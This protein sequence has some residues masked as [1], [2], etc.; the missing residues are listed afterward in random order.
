MNKTKYIWLSAI[1]A[2]VK[3]SCFFG[4]FTLINTLFKQVPAGWSLAIMLFVLVSVT[5]IFYHENNRAKRRFIESDPSENPPSPKSVLRSADL[6]IDTAVC[7]LLSLCSAFAVGYSDIQA[8]FFAKTSIP[9][10]LQALLIGM[11]IGVVCFFVNWFTVYDVRKKWKRD[12]KLSSKNEILK[13]AAYLCF[14]TVL[15][16]IGFYIAMAYAVGLYTY[17]FLIKNYFW[18]ILTILAIIIAASFFLIFFRRLSKRKKFISKLKKASV[19]FGYTL[20]PIKRPYLSLFRKTEGESFTITAHGKSYS[21]KLISGKRKTSPMIFSDQGFLLFQH[22]FRLGKHE[23]F[24]LYSRYPYAFESDT[25][26][27]IIITAIPA[28]CYF[29]DTSGHMREIDTGETIGD[30]TIFSGKG[31]LNS[32]ERDCLY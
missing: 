2:A 29:K 9:D 31:F 25:K 23:L 11:L 14:I 20:S 16:T 24:S 10:I 4:I 27:R 21:C 7:F 8:F 18:Q 26:K 5:W 15:Y 30:Y 19:K 6:I 1:R 3:F 22:I 32:L 17:I 13:I 28:K 12:K